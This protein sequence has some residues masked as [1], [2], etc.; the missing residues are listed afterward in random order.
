MTQHQPQL[1]A[2]SASEASLPSEE[3]R[4]GDRVPGAGA[5][6]KPGETRVMWPTPVTAVQ[7]DP[8]EKTHVDRL[9][10]SSRVLVPLKTPPC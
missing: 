4:A 1:P 10:V 5:S 2:G 8:P 6:G 3:R 9:C 7:M